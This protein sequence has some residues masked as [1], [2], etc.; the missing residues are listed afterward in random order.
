MKLFQIT[1]NG[2][3]M[4]KWQKKRHLSHT[5]EDEGFMNDTIEDMIC[6]IGV[7]AFKKDNVIDTL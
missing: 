4:V 7:D 1:R 2:Y 6:D 3:D 5:V